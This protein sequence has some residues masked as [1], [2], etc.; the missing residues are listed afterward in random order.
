G[1]LN[2][3]APSTMALRAVRLVL[4]VDLREVVELPRLDALNERVPFGGGRHG[5]DVGVVALPDVDHPVFADVHLEALLTLGGGEAGL[6]PCGLG[7]D[8]P[9][10]ARTP[11]HPGSP[12]IIVPE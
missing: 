12:R 4:A 5:H 1:G 3:Q 10:A 6:E 8:H 11:D 9:F 7:H 2:D